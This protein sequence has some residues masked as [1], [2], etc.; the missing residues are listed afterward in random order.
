VMTG[1]AGD[2]RGASRESL[3]GLRDR[4][5][6]ATKGTDPAAVG[7]ELF[8]VVSLLDSAVALR[9]ALTD[10][11]R[12][13]EDR[14]GLAETLL[15]DKVGPATLELVDA[16]VRSSWS[17]QRDL[18]DSLEYLGV[19]AEVQAA[20]RDGQLDE[21]E[22][23]LFRFGRLVDSEGALLRAL[24][25]RAAPPDRRAGLVRTLLEG[26]AHPA[27]VRLVEHAV[28]APRGLTLTRGL[29]RYSKIA[30]GWRDRLVATVYTAIPLQAAEVDR[31][32]DVLAARYGHQLHVNVV[33]DPELLGGIRVELGDEVIDGSVAGRLA[34]VR[35]QVSGAP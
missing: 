34:D 15:R 22:D 6:P 13:G 14:A 21:V 10:P 24:T 7:E 4:L 28:V 32:A 18:P 3:A 29:E 19:L 5:A 2:L 8:A 31:L 33:V 26:K 25:D 20:E 30:A 16:A 35:R 1:G 11:A 17:R 27:A 23:A 9:R 12:S